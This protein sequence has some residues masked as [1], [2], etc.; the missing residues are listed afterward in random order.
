V[1]RA[2]IILLI[3]LFVS[4]CAQKEDPVVLKEGTP[5]YDLGVAL[6]E[7]I[8]GLSPDNN[9]ILIK[10]DYFDISSGE[11]IEML[12]STYAAHVDQL[13]AM[14]VERVTQ[15]VEQNAERLA[16][17]KLLFQASQKFGID[18]PGRQIDSVLQMNY[19][20]AGGET[21]FNNYLKNNGISLDYIRESIT[22]GLA[23]QKYI[24]QTVLTDIEITDTEVEETFAKM[25]LDAEKAT[26]RHIL[27]MTKGKS[28]QEKKQIRNKM[29]G[30]LKKAR[31]G[32]DFAELARTYTEDPGSKNNGGLY[33]DF[34]RGTM[35]KPFEDAAFSVPIGEI[36][37]IVE[38]QYGYHI[39]K[40]VDR[41]KESKSME[42]M[43]PQIEKKLREQKEPQAVQT[44]V[45]Q[46]KSQANF[47]KYEL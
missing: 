39:L 28:E 1:K 10:T 13:K 5:A 41:G 6:G 24:D 20:R 35:V 7:K 31:S 25:D 33:K 17:Q 37:D 46:L 18:V 3:L 22:T 36:S 9:K 14:P 30:I 40:I 47:E 38:T 34:T 19:D 2:F 8:P 23:I 27:L 43:R 29:E 11:V 44:H 15:I 4:A 42:E 26:V 21:Q 16:E 45:E 12:Q 32:E